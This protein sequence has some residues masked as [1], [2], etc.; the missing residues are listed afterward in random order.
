MI[1]F[2]KRSILLPTIKGWAIILPVSLLTLAVFLAYAERFLAVSD[3][4]EADTLIVE[5]W[6]GK[7]GI[8]EAGKVFVS[9][10]YRYI[11]LVGGLEESKWGE[12]TWNHTEYSKELLQKA[13]P[14]IPE[15]SIITVTTDLVTRNRTFGAALKVE[16]E[17]E[18]CSAISA[19]APSNIRKLT[20]FTEAAHARR[21]RLVF[22]RVFPSKVEVG[23]IAW[24][25][26]PL[27]DGE[28]YESSERTKTLITEMIGY[29]YELLIY[30][31]RF[32]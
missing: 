6:I 22:D 9:D 21:S 14:E 11:V 13:Y 10:N 15:H 26:S 23:S 29:L 3:E 28:W 12:K 1:L 8:E 32:L 30:S 5:C 19:K 4:V 7:Y 24:M 16:S 17:I 20:V 31:G 27:Y 18:N 2:A 25:P